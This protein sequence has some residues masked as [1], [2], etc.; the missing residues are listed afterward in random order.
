MNYKNIKKR[1]AIAMPL[2]T[3]GVIEVGGLYSRGL[4]KKQI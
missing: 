4:I 2:V 3:K 1:T